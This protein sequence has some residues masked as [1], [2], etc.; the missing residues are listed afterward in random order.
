MMDANVLIID[1]CFGHQFY[2]PL[3]S[4][5]LIKFRVIPKYVYPN[6]EHFFLT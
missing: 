4:M 1:N 2:I 5:A 6:I 3:L